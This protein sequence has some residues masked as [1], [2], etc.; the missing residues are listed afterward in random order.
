MVTWCSTNLKSGE[1]DPNIYVS[2]KAPSNEEGLKKSVN[3]EDNLEKVSTT[4]QG[5]ANPDLRYIGSP[6]HIRNNNMLNTQRCHSDFLTDTLYSIIDDGFDIQKDVKSDFDLNYESISGSKDP[7]NFETTGYRNSKPIETLE[8]HISNLHEGLG[9]SLRK[10]EFCGK[11]AVSNN[12]LNSFNNFYKNVY[13]Q[14]I[15]NNY[16]ERLHDKSENRIND[17]NQIKLDIDPKAFSKSFF[18]NQQLH[19]Q[20]FTLR[21]ENTDTSSRY[22][23]DEM[24]DPK[25]FLVSQ[26]QR[27]KQ[28]NY[29]HKYYKVTDSGEEQQTNAKFKL[30]TGDTYKHS[31]NNEEHSIGWESNQENLRKT[32]SFHIAQPKKES[33]LDLDKEDNTEKNSYIKNNA[34]TDNQISANV[35]AVGQYNKIN[36]AK[37]EK[38]EDGNLKNSRMKNKN[39]I[40]KNTQNRMKNE[41]DGDEDVEDKTQNNSKTDKEADKG[42]SNLSVRTDESTESYCIDNRPKINDVTSKNLESGYEHSDPETKINCIEIEVTDIEPT[43]KTDLS[44]CNKQRL[45]STAPGLYNIER[46]DDKDSR[47]NDNYYYKHTQNYHMSYNNG[48]MNS[49]NVVKGPWSKE[50]DEKLLRIIKEHTPKNWSKIAELMK[51]RIGKQCRER[52]HNHLHPSIKKTPFTNEEDMIILSLHEKCGNRWSEIA[53][54]LPGRTDNAIKNHWNSALQKKMRRKSCVVDSLVCVRKFDSRCCCSD[55]VKEQSKKRSLSVDSKLSQIEND[56]RVTENDEDLRCFYSSRDRFTENIYNTESEYISGKG[57][58]KNSSDI[59]ASAD[60]INSITEDALGSQEKNAILLERAEQ[61]RQKFD[62]LTEKEKIATI[63][64]LNLYDSR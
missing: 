30:N 25:H 31:K 47:Y 15:I 18:I 3:L 2:T 52:W 40:T 34:T 38:F 19:N 58:L 22:Q 14:D 16:D 55:C 51:T 48:M 24:I 26:S 6:D 49:S 63:A 28:R 29:G 39:I 41:K 8:S 4:L 36:T 21:N 53:K 27:R 37:I 23:R 35:S 42:T 64:L 10:N 60:M 7:L 20:Y 11:S 50:E 17:T 46:S 12:N 32:K 59:S 62:R 1:K 9:S 13:M 56:D 5:D 54:Y 44:F 45:S 61:T 57:E 43:K 33:C